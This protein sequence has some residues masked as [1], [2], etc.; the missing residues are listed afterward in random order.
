MNRR[1]MKPLVSIVMPIY[2]GRKYILQMLESVVKQTYRPLQLILYD[3]ASRD[4][5]LQLISKWKEK[6]IDKDVYIEIHIS[7][8]NRGI[9]TSTSK[10]VSYARGKYIFLADQDD[11]W[12]SEKIQKQVDY[13]ER[14]NDCMVCFC[15][16]EIINSDEETMVQ[17][18]IIKNPTYM[19]KLGVTEV[20]SKPACFPANCMC[21][22]NTHLDKI[23]PIHNRYS[24][25]DTFI[26][27]MAAHFGDVV[28][29]RDTLVK[30]RIHGNNLS[31]VYF[32]ENNWNP[33]PVYRIK[34]KQLKKAKCIYKKD[35]EILRK[36]LYDRF[37]EDYD[38][39][40]HN[41]HRVAEK[42]IYLVAL[43]WLLKKI[44]AGDLNKFHKL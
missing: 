14:N 33:I 35:E 13:M 40:S 27:I 44:I 36:V 5:T 16:R 25:H 43:I 39:V 6:Q 4:D 21:L 28:L 1:N 22:R 10:A 34:L 8:R 7:K 17:H 31:G 11:I 26:T 38:Y 15:R 30:Y 19:K 9:K 41:Y 20:I 18:E 24:E 3:D 12:F 42:H 2:N 23:F 29:L 32:A 37:Q